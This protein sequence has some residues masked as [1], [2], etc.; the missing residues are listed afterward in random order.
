[1]AV[2]VLTLPNG[3]RV[4]GDFEKLRTEL[5]RK[6]SFDDKDTHIDALRVLGALLNGR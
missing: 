4:S 2:Q 3:M 5:E 1:M 6:A